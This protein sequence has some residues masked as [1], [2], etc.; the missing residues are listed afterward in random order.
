M[1]VVLRKGEA[2]PTEYANLADWS[3]ERS[4]DAP[5]SITFALNNSTSDAE[6]IITFLAYFG[7]KY[8]KSEAITTFAEKLI[9]NIRQNNFVE[10][11]YSRVAS[12]VLDRVTYV[13]DPRGA[14][15]VRSPVKLLR[16]FCQRGFAQGDC[17]DMALLTA[18]LMTALGFKARIVAVKI[19]GSDYYN[20]VLNQV[21]VRGQWKWF[22]GCNKDNPT[23]QWT[24]FISK[25][26]S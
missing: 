26:I 11:Q 20:H 25:D 15:Y 12:F 9:R 2:M 23:K 19:N 17:D 24:D 7:G 4:E 10:E 14:E 3:P 13:A 16:Q 5:R 21:M 6:Q 8:G 18:S 1:G 22:D